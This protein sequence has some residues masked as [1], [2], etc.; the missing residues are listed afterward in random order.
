MPSS[1]LDWS[2][3]YL[4]NV[5]DADTSV[6]AA[7]TETATGFIVDLYVPSTD[8]DFA[9]DTLIC[10]LVCTTAVSGT[11]MTVTCVPYY[12]DGNDAYT[13]SGNPATS[14]ATSTGSSVQLASGINLDAFYTVAGVT[15]TD[16]SA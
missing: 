4:T 1:P 16:P 7:L 13:D 8:A 12:Y 2:R 11:N 6:T 14:A 10:K 15:R 9:A 5:E 3:P